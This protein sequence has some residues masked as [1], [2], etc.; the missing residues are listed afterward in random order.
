V[1][2]IGEAIREVMRG[3]APMSP[4]IARRVLGMFT[5]MGPAKSDYGLTEREKEMLELMTQGKTMKEIAD[6]AGVSYHTVDSH[7]RNIYAKLHVNSRAG[8]VAKA[9]KE[10]L[11]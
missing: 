3:G 10:R 2:Q 11:V 6:V 1:G 5:K 4:P 9:V 8:A 7:L